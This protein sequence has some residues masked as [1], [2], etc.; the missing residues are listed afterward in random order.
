MNMCM[1]FMKLNNIFAY[2]ED[3]KYVFIFAEILPENI[4]TLNKQKTF[5]YVKRSDISRRDIMFLCISIHDY[6][7]TIY[8]ENATWKIIVHICVI[9]HGDNFVKLLLSAGT[10]VRIYVMLEL[11]HFN[12]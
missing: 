7:T 6:K 3:F 5:V 8:K 12:D 9:L 4:F 1:V 11:S 2:L 10:N